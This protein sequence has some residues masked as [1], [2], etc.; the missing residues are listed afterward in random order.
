MFEI[1]GMGFSVRNKVNPNK[2]NEDYFI[3]DNE[4]QIYIIAD[5]VT[6]PDEEYTVDAESSSS[7]VLSKLFVDS[8]HS[9][10]SSIPDENT[11]WKTILSNGIH[12]AN[13]VVSKRYVGY[14]GRVPA[15]VFLAVI[16]RNGILYFAHV[17]DLCGIIIRDTARI[18]FTTSGTYG[19]ERIERFDEFK[20]KFTQ[21]YRYSSVLNQISSP[22]GYGAITGSES[23]FDFISISS[24]KLEL[25]DVLVLASDG[26]N[27][28][29]TMEKTSK[30]RE[31]KP[32]E[33]IKSSEELV[34]LSCGI[35]Y[36]YDKP[37]FARYADDKTI[38]K[39]IVWGK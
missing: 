26:L 6:R 7:Q 20:S 29:L 16:I 19:V 17:G 11:D 3:C 37:P 27:E 30:L 1:V 25:G 21:Q 38:I 32:E 36:S 33:I 13:S 15:T 5:G 34:S 4:L 8:L 14:S 31:M 23:V 24:L 12:F 35:E 22:I 28:Y 2:P 39:V 10:L 18:V 9:Y